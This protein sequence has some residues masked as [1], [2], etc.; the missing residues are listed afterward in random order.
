M[1][2]AVKVVEINFADLIGRA[3]NGYDLMN[4]LNKRPEFKVNQI[5]AV[6]N[7]TDRNVVSVDELSVIRHVVHNIEERFSIPNTIS[8][9][10]SLIYQTNEFQDADLLHFHILHNGF[11]SLLDYPKLFNAH[12]ALW[13]V[14]DPWLVSGGCVHPLACDQWKYGCKNCPDDA[15][16]RYKIDKNQCQLLWQIKKNIFQ[17]INPHIIVSSDFMADYIRKSPLTSHFENINIIPFGIK[18][19]DFHPELRKQKKQKFDLDEKKITV[20]C[21]GDK[22]IKGAQYVIEAFKQVDCKHKFEILTVSAKLKEELPENISVHQLGWI[23]DK[24]K[25][26]DFLEA[27]DIFIMPSKAESFGVMAIEA[28]AAGCAIL[29]FKGTT[30]E[31]VT[32]SPKCGIAVEY[33]SS[34]SLAEALTRIAFSREEITHRGNLGRWIAEKEYDFETYV[35]RH[36]KLYEKVFYENFQGGN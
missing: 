22:G 19:H 25:M 28:M 32:H 16:L 7:S 31:S 3:F 20:G 4:A 35:E 1:I 27:C 33:C 9:N 34:K 10:G 11:V 36:R 8:P 24:D 13:T 2:F 17:E 15:D 23:N 6:K 14:H 12:P 5:V 30:V 18:V 26:A 21:R 29:C